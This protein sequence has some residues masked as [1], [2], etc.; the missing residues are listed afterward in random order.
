M[1]FTLNSMRFT[2]NGRYK[3]NLFGRKKNQM[4]AAESKKY[5]RVQDWIDEKFD[6]YNPLRDNEEY[7]NLQTVNDGVAELEKNKFY[8]IT[9]RVQSYQFNGE[10]RL[11]L[12]LESFVLADQPAP[13]EYTNIAIPSFE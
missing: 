13:V 8:D 4:D 11:R 9:I 3:T 6:C 5:K 10:T 2:G 1:S 12:I 7:I